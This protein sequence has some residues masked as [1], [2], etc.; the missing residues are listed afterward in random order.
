[1]ANEFG[2]IDGGQPKFSEQK[3][4]AD[5]RRTASSGLS[6][7]GGFIHLNYGDPRLRGQ[8]AMRIFMEMGD[9]PSC[10]VL[11]YLMQ[12][13]VA[14][15]NWDV[16]EFSEERDDIDNAHFLKS[17][18]HDMG[19]PWGDFIGNCMVGVTQFGFAPYEQVYKKRDGRIPDDENAEPSQ[20]SDGKIGWADFQQIGQDTITRWDFD[21]N[22]RVLGLWQ[23]ASPTFQMVNIPAIRM[24]NFKRATVRDNPMGE[25]IF[26][27]AFA[28]W[29]KKVSLS[30]I[31]GI[32][33]ERD[34][35]GLPVAKVPIE[36]LMDSASTDKKQLRD[37]LKKIV[38][39]MRTDE[40]MG[41]LWPNAYDANGQEMYKLELLNSGGSRSIDV[42][43]VIERYE[44][45]IFRTALADFLGLGSGTNSSGSWA[46]HNDKTQLFLM[47]LRSYL[48]I[49]AE[50]LN[51][52][53]VPRLFAV[54]GVE[55][56][57]Y[58]QIYHTPLD[59]VDIQQL[60]AAISSLAG[61]GMPIF[62]NEEIEHRLFEILGLPAPAD[63]GAKKKSKD[64]EVNTQFAGDEPKV[65]EHDDDTPPGQTPGEAKPV[66]RDQQDQAQ[67]PKP[68][69]RIA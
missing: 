15:V 44:T 42:G 1:V 16:R 6:T 4:H 29:V 50:T 62:P 41:V 13:I 31:E 28:P 19:Q 8:N 26:R 37:S 12:N 40:Q 2:S 43:K 54:N 24:V 38:C 56:K 63:D 48:K 64:L 66:D 21:A 7:M 14:S 20:Y 46:M 69:S 34:T 36:I 49:I 68:L 35:C 67:R 5:T 58:P 39:D 22:N 59:Q 3:L 61:A 23:Q 11:L 10:G 57:G 65:I 33:I 51:R 27:R 25:S 55:A 18:M 17:C 60:A 47:G 30:N 53:A 52:V 9:D 32:A 45:Q